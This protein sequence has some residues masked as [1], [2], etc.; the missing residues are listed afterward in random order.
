MAWF[1][2]AARIYR[3][4]LFA[5]PA[6]FRHEYGAEMEE[7]FEQ[8]ARQEP[9]ARLW[10]E[11]LADIAWSAAEEHWHILLSDLRYGARMLAGAPGFTAAALL[12]I[13][14]GIGATTAVFSLVN[15]VLIRSMPYGACRPLGLFVEPEQPLAGRNS[16]GRAG[17]EY[18]GF[19]RLDE[20]E[21]LVHLA[22]DVGRAD[23]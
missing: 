16:S 1:P 23:V 20:I 18:S 19:L 6:E 21:P 8:R 11:T 5:Y 13:A 4:L 9:M 22:H 2:S 17:A 15:A 3:A 12:A 14:L 7:V 10:P